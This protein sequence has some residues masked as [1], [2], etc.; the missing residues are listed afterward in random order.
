MSVLSP[1]FSFL[2]FYEDCR[3]EERRRSRVEQN[4]AG[5][6]IA[7]LTV[8]EQRTQV[9][10]MLSVARHF[11]HVTGL[12]VKQNQTCDILWCVGTVGTGRK[13]ESA[14]VGLARASRVRQS[15]RK[16]SFA[17]RTTKPKQVEKSRS[18]DACRIHTSLSCPA[19]N[20]D[21]QEGRPQYTLRKTLSV[22][23]CEMPSPV[24]SDEEQQ[25]VVGVM[26]A[27]WGCTLT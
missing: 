27:H 3:G 9:R 12:S 23:E 19:D 1:R 8:T 16:E 2:R 18:F 10:S 6:F 20:R 26:I 4:S 25:T 14:T 17:S 5:V 22:S 15:Q 7:V 21:S 13:I 11:M 24:Y